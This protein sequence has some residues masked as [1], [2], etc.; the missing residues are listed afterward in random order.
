MV[1]IIIP[2][3]KS[4]EWLYQEK[5]GL[6]LGSRAFEPNLLLSHQSGK[7]ERERQRENAIHDKD[8]LK[9]K[10]RI[11]K[12]GSLY[13]PRDTQGEREGERERQTETKRL[14]KLPSFHDLDELTEGPKE[15]TWNTR[16]TE[17]ER[18]RKGGREGGEGRGER[19]F[20]FSQNMFI[21]WMNLKLNRRSTSNSC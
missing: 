2:S 10:G 12:R 6:I 7:R 3:T 5:G 4:L 9:T 11:H 15:S 13:C 1:A 19:D 20:C 16:E 8:K 21:I 17:R 14:H 18:E